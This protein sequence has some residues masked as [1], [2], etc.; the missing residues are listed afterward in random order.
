ML[1]NKDKKGCFLCTSIRYFIFSVFLI[2][3]IS[4]TASDQL[5]LLNFITPWNF[6]I[7]VMVIGFA[8]FAFKLIEY[9]RDKKD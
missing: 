4:L 1:K 3:I 5:H 2:I 9:Y 8:I 6:A 7:F